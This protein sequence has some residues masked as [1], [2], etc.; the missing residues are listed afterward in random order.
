MQA[1]R[2]RARYY[3]TFRFSCHCSIQALCA[4]SRNS[5]LTGRR[6]DALHL[7]DFY[8]YWRTSVGN[9]TT[10]PQYF[11]ENGYETYSI[12]K[13]F[14]PGISSNY[15]DDYPLSWSHLPYHPSTDK[16][17]DAAVC[18]D[19][20][21]AIPKKNLLCP[22][23]VTDQPEGSLPDIQSV[24]YAK[25]ILSKRKSNKPFFLAVGF[26]KPHI[27]FKY[28][29]KYLDRIPLKKVHP[30]KHPYMPLNMPT[31]AWHPWTD[32]RRRDDIHRLNISFPYGIMPSNWALKVRQNYYAA[33]TYIDDLLGILMGCVNRNDTIVVLTSDHGW[34]LGENGLWAKYSNFDVALKV[35]L[36]FNIPNVKHKSI[37]SPVEL[38]D[39]FPT[40]VQLSGIK[41]NIPKCS[42]TE[43]AICFD[44]QSLVPLMT[45]ETNRLNSKLFAISQYPRPSVYPKRN[46]DKPRLKD[47]KIMGYSI[48]TKRYRYT[49]WI[50]FNSSKFT[51]NWDINYGVELYDHIRDPNEAYNVGFVSTY[52]KIVALLSKKLR[53]QIE[54]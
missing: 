33:E 1:G 36:I 31:V 18:K 13:I 30:P 53:A 45:S 16:Y 12:G 40:L 51:R 32:V 42:N 10:I 11:K 24:D 47:I 2:T 44:G 19:T 28:P 49:E 37:E 4:P 9:F 35:P 48:R 41:A 43:A 46:S 14:H 8:S 38:I 39:I 22:V 52:Q 17:K 26:H 34:S 5:M 27:P 23:K 15:T 50:S 21:T 7:Y 20:P 54:N 3:F 25:E 29:Q 6:P